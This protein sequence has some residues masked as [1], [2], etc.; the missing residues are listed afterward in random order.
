M[1]REILYDHP[2]RGFKRIAEY[3]IPS[4]PPL[5]WYEWDSSFGPAP[6]RSELVKW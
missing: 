4:E 3:R 2:A 6:V 1:R 5:V